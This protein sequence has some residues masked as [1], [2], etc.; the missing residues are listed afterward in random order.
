MK[1]CCPSCGSKMRLPDSAADARM[2]CPR[3][4]TEFIPRLGLPVAKAVA[5]PARSNR[6]AI[7]FGGGL[8]AL[9][10]LVVVIAAVSRLTQATPA[11]ADPP[12]EA[13]SPPEAAISSADWTAIR[14]IWGR[15]DT[16][17][18][19]STAPL[20]SVAK[21]PPTAHSLPPILGSQQIFSKCAPGVVAVVVF[22]GDEIKSLGSGFLMKYPLP[23]AAVMPGVKH[24]GAGD[25]RV[26][27]HSQIKG[28]KIFTC[29]VV[30]NEHVIADA[31]DVYLRFN[32]SSIVSNA[33][34]RH[35]DKRRDLAVLEVTYAA[36]AELP[37][38]AFS[39]ASP[40]VGAPVYVIGAPEGLVFSLT[41]GIVSAYRR[42]EGV[43]WLQ[44]SVGVAPGSSGAP[45]LDERGRVAGVVTARMAGEGFLGV[46]STHLEA[47]EFLKSVPRVVKRSGAP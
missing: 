29:L 10:A 16:P 15:D 18:A 12:A 13:P 27:A 44:I 45:L 47:T 32:D 8:A 36:S 25:A 23:Q 11:T 19:S 33:W 39:D 46:A 42:T 26:Y 31:E 22:E 28:L 21:E 24:K 4:G 17:T 7:F 2:F 34:V 43:G 37:Y 41:Q 1:A 20:G 3:C 6:L 5:L 35:V 30:T 40:P 14:A 9:L 38:L